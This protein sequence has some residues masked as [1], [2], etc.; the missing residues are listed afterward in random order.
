MSFIFLFTIYISDNLSERSKDE[1]AFT[2][3]ERQVRILL[4]ELW[5]EGVDKR[6]PLPDKSEGGVNFY[7]QVTK[8]SNYLLIL[9]LGIILFLFLFS[10]RDKKVL[11][12]EKESMASVSFNISGFV[13]RLCLLLEAG[14]TVN[15]AIIK[16]TKD[17]ELSDFKDEYFN[18]QLHKVLAN[19]E[20]TKKDIVK[21]LREF[22]F[23]TNDPHFIRITGIIDENRLKG[24]ELKEKLLL[25]N[26]MLWEL[27]K[28][29]SLEKGKVAETKLIIPL[30]IQ[31]IVLLI[32]TVGPVFLS[33]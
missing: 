17:N 23:R 16:I 20:K 21:G 18:E 22:S 13:T 25:E 3:A 2:Q 4:K 26:H 32:I 7:Y 24:T 1:N 15:T 12:L 10:N 27:R 30:M 14:L 11:R 29:Q 31:L 19:Y 33:M 8:N 9:P 28:K 5:Q 6:I